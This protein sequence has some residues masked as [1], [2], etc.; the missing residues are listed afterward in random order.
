PPPHYGSATSYSFT[1]ETVGNWRWQVSSVLSNGQVG[2]APH[3]RSFR[4][5]PVVGVQLY[6]G[7]NYAGELQPVYQYSSN[8]TCVDLGANAYKSESFRLQGGYVGNYEVVFYND[9]ACGVYNARYGQDASTFGNLN[10]QF[11]SL[12]I[13][14]LEGVQLCSNADF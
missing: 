5:D 6:D 14:K 9:H 10:N 2:P 4:V 7:T 3:T 1:P 11:A 12:R 8:G 13:E